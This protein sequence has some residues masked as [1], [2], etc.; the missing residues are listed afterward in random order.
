[1]MAF[2]KISLKGFAVAAL[3]VGAMLSFELSSNA[4]TLLDPKPISYQTSDFAVDGINGSVGFLGGSLDGAANGMAL[5]SLSAPI[6]YFSSFGIQGDLAFGSYD[7]VDANSSAAAALHLFWRNPGVGMLGVYG[8]WGYLSPVHSGRLGIE[9]A[10]YSGQWT[11]EGLFA[12]EFGQNVYTKFVDEIDVS[13]YVDDNTK[14]S[15]G[16]RF[17]ARGNVVN[18]GFEKQFGEMTG[19]A[20]SLFGEAEAGEDDFYQVFAGIRASF[21]TGGARTMIERDRSSGVRVRIPRNLA[22]ITQCA[23]VDNPFAAPNWLTG[24][25]LIKPG[26]M[27]ETL[28]ASRRS[29]NRVSSSGIFKP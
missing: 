4:Q 24:I 6:P 25:H 11:I 14:L 13:Y 20:W 1:M 17:T 10:H 5:L 18:I 15:F 3:G 27:T 12:L 2:G 21:G 19:S 22:S 8:D 26:S 28:C 29:L 9:A 16:H 7:G 23:N